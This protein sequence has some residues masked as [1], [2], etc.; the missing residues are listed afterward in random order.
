V[1]VFAQEERTDVRFE[2]MK[3]RKKRVI[4]EQATNIVRF[5]IPCIF[6]NLSGSQ[7]VSVFVQD[8]RTVCAICETFCQMSERKLCTSNTFTT[9]VEYSRP[10][11]H[12][13]AGRIHST[14]E[15]ISCRSVRVIRA[16]GT[17]KWLT[18]V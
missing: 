5:C 14:C 1:R 7:R 8:E 3:E 16:H 13:T 10:A 12:M 15:G 2:G 9:Q 17:N 6:L 18:L 4:I 11:C